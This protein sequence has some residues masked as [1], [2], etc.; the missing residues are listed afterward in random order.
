MIA[1]LWQLFACLPAAP[2]QQHQPGAGLR[3]QRWSCSLEN[4]GH[5]AQPTRVWMHCR[6]GL[7]ADHANLLFNAS[8]ALQLV[9][10][11]FW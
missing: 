1:E 9:S 2:E 7:L 4:E 8:L 11:R 6:T 3:L 10:C 5:T